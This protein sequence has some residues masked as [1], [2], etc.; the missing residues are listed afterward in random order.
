VKVLDIQLARTFLEILTAG[1][2]RNAASRLHVTQAAVSL[3]V[4]KLEEELGREVFIRSKSGVTLTPAGEQFE[5]FARSMMK[6]W[7]E[8]RYHVAVPEG[9]DETLIVGSEYSLWP[10][11]GFRWL[12]LLERQ[13]PT[14]SI[15]AD[16]GKPDRLL[17]LMLDGVLDIAIM[18]SPQ[19]RPGLEVETLL[20]DTLILVSTDPDYTTELDEDYI[21]IDYGDEFV[22]AHGIHFP[23]FQTSQVTLSLGTL[24]A[25]Y[26][27]EHKRAGYLPARF[28][29]DFIDDEE[30]HVVKGAPVFPFP[31][32]VVWNPEKEGEVLEKSLRLLRRVAERID[33][34]THELF[35][36]EGIN[37]KLSFTP[38]IGLEGTESGKKD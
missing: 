25:R 7:E 14:V 8:A 16:V 4:K 28:V 17:R 3:R 37:D 23:H 11:F 10:K 18:Y 6:V 29:Q 1:N 34:D 22:H 24:S 27:I 21:F 19:L 35:E 33:E 13:L 15:R 26:I 2:F 32:Y 30:L 20:E 36:D 12:R 5:R 31:A 9:F 38:G